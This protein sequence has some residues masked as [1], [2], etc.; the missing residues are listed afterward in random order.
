MSQILLQMSHLHTKKRIQGRG[1]V[2]SFCFRDP[3]AKSQASSPLPK[4][5]F[6]QNMIAPDLMYIDVIGD[7]EPTGVCKLK[8]CWCHSGD[9]SN[10]NH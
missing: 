7:P 3:K 4:G 9:N 1:N 10:K 5:I 2:Y 6:S 8:H